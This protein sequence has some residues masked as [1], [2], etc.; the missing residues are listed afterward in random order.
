MQG[1]I[2]FTIIYD[3]VLLLHDHAGKGKWDKVSGLPVKLTVFTGLI[4]PNA[5]LLSD[6]SSQNGSFSNLA[7][8]PILQ[9]LYR[10]GMILPN[11]PNNTGLKPVLIGTSTQILAQSEYIYHENYQIDK[12]GIIST[13]IP[14]DVAEEI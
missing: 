2:T 11:H 9:M 7:E 10:Q 14:E 13:G 12:K 4:Y 1:F 8:F 5:I 6:V 3:D